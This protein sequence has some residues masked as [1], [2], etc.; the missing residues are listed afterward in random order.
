MVLLLNILPDNGSDAGAASTTATL[1][2][3]NWI[4]NGTKSWISNGDEAKG[5]VLFATT[6][7]SLKHKVSQYYVLVDLLALVNLSFTYF[8]P[9]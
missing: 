8:V 6:D 3:D 2:G 4:I 7:K 9:S 5:C 1:D